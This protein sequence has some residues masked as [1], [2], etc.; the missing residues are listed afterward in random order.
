MVHQELDTRAAQ[1]AEIVT[2]RATLDA[3]AARR[4]EDAEGWRQQLTAAVAQ[5]ADEGALRELRDALADC[6]RDGAECARAV[7]D[8]DA[9]LTAHDAATAEVTADLAVKTFTGLCARRDAEDEALGDMLLELDAAL[10]PAVERWAATHAEVRAAFSAA[11][12]QLKTLGRPR[13][14]IADE[15][16]RDRMAAQPAAWRILDCITV[17][18]TWRETG[19]RMSF[20]APAQPPMLRGDG[21][22]M[23][24]IVSER[25][26]AERATAAVGRA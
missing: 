22:A 24:G 17:Y 20:G 7:A 16:A 10:R 18:R 15:E 25:R 9:A 8:L 11:D 5:G 26:A 21:A 1:R 23:A 4:A 6:E 12:H 14:S 2:S 13:L 3:R 19:E